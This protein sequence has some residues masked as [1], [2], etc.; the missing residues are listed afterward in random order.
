M[1]RLSWRGRQQTDH[2]RYAAPGGQYYDYLVHAL[3]Q[4]KSGKRQNPLMTPMAAP[5]S[6]EDISN[7]AMYFSKQQG[8]SVKY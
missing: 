4:Y 3:Q 8:L 2:A 7:L 6:K 1:C 5:L